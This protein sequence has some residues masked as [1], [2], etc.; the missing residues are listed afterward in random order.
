MSHPAGTIISEAC[1]DVFDALGQDEF[2]QR[3]SDAAVP[4]RVILERGVKKYGEYGVV[5][6]IVNVVAFLKSQWSPEVAD[7]VTVDSVGK[8]VAA[9][10]EDNGVVVKV[11]LHG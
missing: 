6:A 9:I 10:E 11:V 5:V 3:G 1:A 8:G 7:V 4:V 2:V